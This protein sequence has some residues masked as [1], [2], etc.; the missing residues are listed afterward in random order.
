MYTFS[1]KLYKTYKIRINN[2]KIIIN[3]YYYYLRLFK[4]CIL[5]I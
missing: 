5:F 3:L 4:V 1:G 2:G